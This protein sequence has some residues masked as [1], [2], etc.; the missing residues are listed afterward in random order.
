MHLMLPKL[1][2]EQNNKTL[3]T[4]QDQTQMRLTQVFNYHNKLNI[5]LLSISNILFLKKQSTRR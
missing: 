5:S 4:G 1:V 3:T 2:M